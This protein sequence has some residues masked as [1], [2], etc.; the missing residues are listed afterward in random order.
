MPCMYEQL[1]RRYKIQ[2]NTILIITSQW[3]VLAE[4]SNIVNI[5]ETFNE[6]FNQNIYKFVM[7]SIKICNL[8]SGHSWINWKKKQFFFQNLKHKEFLMIRIK[9]SMKLMHWMGFEFMRGFLY[10]FP[11][12]FSWRIQLKVK[13]P[14]TSGGL[15]IISGRLLDY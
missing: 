15:K 8:I 9:L 13:I 14:A 6:T 7:Q 2:S 4:H 10:F 3:K 5:P 1:K 11:A 12:K